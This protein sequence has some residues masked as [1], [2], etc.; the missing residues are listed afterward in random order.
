MNETI[1]IPAI[2]W[3]AEFWE[4]R[5]LRAPLLSFEGAAEVTLRSPPPLGQPMQ[6]REENGLV[7]RNGETLVGEVG[8]VRFR[9]TFPI[10]PDAGAARTAVRRFVEFKGRFSSLF[11]LRRRT[12]RRGWAR[13]RTGP[14][15][16][17]EIVATEWIPHEN[18]VG[19][20]GLIP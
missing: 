20:N 16:G 18:S 13:L 5:M 6:V 1:M 3:S 7:V 9:W 19:T 8:H 4:W 11:R 14:I 17:S 2:Q 10:C 15:D 12:C